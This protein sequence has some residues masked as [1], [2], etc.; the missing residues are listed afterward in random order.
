ME[1]AFQRYILYKKQIIESGLRSHLLTPPIKQSGFIP[2]IMRALP[3]IMCENFNRLP[4][5]DSSRVMMFLS[6]YYY[7][8]IFTPSNTTVSQTI[9][10]LFLTIALSSS[11][12]VVYIQIVNF[13]KTKREL[14]LFS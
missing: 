3:K 14:I 12:K 2:E 5:P 9:N 13:C 1:F 4:V 6:G 8:W 10:L 7:R 11:P